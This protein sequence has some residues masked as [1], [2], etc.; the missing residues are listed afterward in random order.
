MLRLLLLALTWALL[1]AIAGAIARAARPWPSSVPRPG[2]R[3]LLLGGAATGLIGGWLGA[4]VFG[5]F[6][7]AANALWVAIAALVAG[8]WLLSRPRPRRLLAAAR[9]LVVRPTL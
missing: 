6:F 3:A 7:G 9:R 2:W 4:L 5:S 8:P 1:G